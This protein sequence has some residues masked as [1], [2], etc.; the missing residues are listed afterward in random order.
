MGDLDLLRCWKLPVGVSTYDNIELTKH[1]NGSIEITSLGGKIVK[2]PCARF[3]AAP[4]APELWEQKI[5]ESVAKP[6]RDKKIF[7]LQPSERNI[8]STLPA[9]IVAPFLE[10]GLIESDD[11]YKLNFSCLINH[12]PFDCNYVGRKLRWSL[13]EFDLT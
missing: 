3:I 10:D 7:G 11:C 5:K 4:T 2:K 12:I 9:D 6:T 13:K 1:T 8:L